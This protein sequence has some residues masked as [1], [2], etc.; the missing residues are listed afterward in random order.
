MFRI[1]LSVLFFSCCFLLKGQGSFQY[2]SYHQG[3]LRNRSSPSN[4]DFDDNG[5]V[6]LSIRYSIHVF[7]GSSS[8][9]E[10]FNG[11]FRNGTKALTDSSYCCG[12]TVLGLGDSINSV[13]IPTRNEYF[14]DE[15]DLGPISWLDSIV[16]T[17]VL[18]GGGSGI[19]FPNGDILT[20]SFG[21]AELTSAIVGIQFLGADGYHNA[22]VRFENVETPEGHSVTRVADWAYN[23]SPGE[24]ILAGML[25]V[26]EPRTWMM[27]LP[28]LVILLWR[29]R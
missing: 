28:G 8:V 29:P 9:E 10:S 22:W 12:A 1:G 21:I 11:D 15:T 25:Q 17:S 18:L 7:N 3:Q 26:P 4:F 23:L 6:D 13:S 19:L 27:F 16:S 5:T 2:V 24:S 20:S 14:Q